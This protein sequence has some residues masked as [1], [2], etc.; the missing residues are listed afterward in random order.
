MEKTLIFA[1]ITF[2]SVDGSELRN[3]SKG[4]KAFYDLANGDL[5]TADFLEIMEFLDQRFNRKCYS[6]EGDYKTNMN[7]RDVLEIVSNL[8]AEMRKISSDI[9]DDRSHFQDEI[10]DIKKSFKVFQNESETREAMER[11]GFT[12]PNL[13]CNTQD[14]MKCLSGECCLV[15]EV[16]FPNWA[17]GKQAWQSSVHYSDK[18]TAEAAVDGNRNS[19]LK[20]GK[21][22]IHTKYEANPWWMVDLATEKPVGRVVMVN[23]GDGSWNRLRNVVVTVGSD[24]DEHG[25]V[26]GRFAGPGSKGQIIE[27]NCVQKLRGQYVKVTMNSSNY[28]HICEVEVYSE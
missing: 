24:R 2:C 20:E 28:L 26:C 8:E 21:S 25:E 10:S 19:L 1:I 9:A 17:L 15:T 5:E 12:S 6:L 3:L 27:I 22:C 18:G 14:Y 13:F 23:R 16:T 11:T 4:V 7:T